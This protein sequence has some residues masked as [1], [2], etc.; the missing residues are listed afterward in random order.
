LIRRRASAGTA[1]EHVERVPLVA[2]AAR[3]IADI[4]MQ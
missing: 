1:A 4:A 2:I 3:I